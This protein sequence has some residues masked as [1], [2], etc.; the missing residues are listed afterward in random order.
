MVIDDALDPE[1]FRVEQRDAFEESSVRAAL[2]YPIVVGGRI[3]G[4]L[5]ASE[6][7]GPR[8][9]TDEDVTLMEGFA[10]EIGRALDHARAFELQN[11]MVERLGVLDRSKNDFL[12]EVS[13]ELRGP[14]ASVLG[15][16]E[17]LTDESADAVSDEQ[18][19]MLGIVERSGEKLL[20]LISNLLMMSRMEAGTFEPRLALVDIEGMVRRV[21]D[22]LRPA[23][24]Q[25]AARASTSTSSPVSSSSPTRRRSSARCTTSSTNA[26]KFTPVGGRIDIS[27]RSDERLTS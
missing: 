3:G 26:V 8:A 18:R 19:H 7:R 11:Q 21:C 15:Y 5:V 24:A 14:L 22:G 1:Q 16:I 17:L 2:S 27:T 12:A 25:G 20:V 13:R 23:V 10:R 6:Q 9:W 4:V